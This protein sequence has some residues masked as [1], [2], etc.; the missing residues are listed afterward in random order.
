MAADDVNS[1]SG[2]SSGNGG[3][4]PAA[5]RR[6]QALFDSASK[7]LQSNQFDYAIDLLSQCVVGDPGALIYVQKLLEALYR[8]Y[9][10]NRKGSTLASMRSAGAKASIKKSTMTKDWPGVIKNGIEVLKL[11]PWDIPTL[12]NM[13]KACEMLGQ[14]DTQLAY[15]KGGL[16][17]DQKS[18]E[19]NREAAIALTK[20]GD[21]DQA[22]ACWTRVRT[23][24]KADVDEANREVANLQVQKTMIQT[25]SRM[26]KHA[27]AE[28]SAS[29]EKSA[30]SSAPT[31]GSKNLTQAQRLEEKISANPADAT[32]YVELADYYT[33][34]ERWSDAES[35]LRRA[36]D[37]TGGDIRIREQ[38]EDVQLLKA[39]QQSLI[40]DKRAAES[41]TPEAVD[42][43][44]RMRVELNRLETEVYRSRVD[45]YPTN[46]TWKYELG[47]RL[48]KAG[49]FNEAIKLLQEARGDQK[50]KGVVLLDLGECFHQIKQYKL[51]MQHYAKAIEEIPEKEVEYRKKALYRAGSLARGLGKEDPSQ[52]AEAEKHL[53]QLAEMDFAYRDVADL[54]DKIAKERNKE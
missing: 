44:Q 39:K 21:Y 31:A 53:S 30:G 26:E 46:T 10:N 5:R 15:L 40:A 43:A 19:V 1:N 34:E 23:A 18:G 47:V 49:N 13:A 7:S 20:L 29:D 9:N 22:I 36:L 16:N 27:S 51:A 42:Q 4:S 24:P 2:N 8:K 50:R 32:A 37:A 38:L 14:S 11:N 12:L 33:K 3:L 54:L 25:T 6:L 41:K 28:G 45:R 17:A 35:T 52:L 48:K